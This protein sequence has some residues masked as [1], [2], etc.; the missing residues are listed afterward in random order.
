MFLLSRALAATAA[1][2]LLV[3]LG[4]ATA[5][6]VGVNPMG[7][8]AGEYAALSLTGSATAGE[9]CD[10]ASPL[11]V[12]PPCQGLLAVSLL[13]EAQGGTVNFGGAA[14][15]REVEACAADPARCTPS[16]DGTI[17]EAQRIAA[18]E[19]DFAQRL[20][21][22][23]VDSAQRTATGGVDAGQGF[24]RAVT[25]AA[26]ATGNGGVDLGQATAGTVA[27]DPAGF[28]GAAAAEAQ[29]TLLQ[30]SEDAADRV[31]ATVAHVEATAA[32]VQDYAAMLQ[33]D[34]L[35]AL[36][37][38]PQRAQEL[39]AR[40]VEI[41]TETA[42]RAVAEVQGTVDGLPDE[43]VQVE[44]DASCDT[45]AVSV[46]GDSSA[47]TLAASGMGSATA[48]QP[49]LLCFA[50]SGGGA[51]QGYFAVSALGPAQ[52]CDPGT[53]YVCTAVS[54]A[55]PAQGDDYALSVLGD[56]TAGD[57]AVSVLGQ[58]TAPLAIDGSP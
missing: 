16:A 54:I 29:E 6:P 31:E 30:T 52:A 8:A 18:G 46:L 44:A 56:A 17:D 58:A 4:I 24:A 9:G 23:V 48:C 45:V 37:N 38:A 14:V 32:E 43:C 1:A 53:D 26:Q 34:L 39:A 40:G 33:R 20:G 12:Q 35:V 28:A 47:H 10:Y 57:V 36:E 41:A 19:V 49:E 11:P 55:G 7:D 22:G 25:D 21:D 42:D 2:G 27:A 3:C 50:V 51:A 13:G 5:S 15:A